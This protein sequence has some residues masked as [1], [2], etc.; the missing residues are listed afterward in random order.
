M[1]ALRFIGRARFNHVDFATFVACACLAYYSEW[2]WY[3][4][5]LIVGVSL[6]AIAEVLVTRHEIREIESLIR[7][8]EAKP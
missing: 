7:E 4:A 8:A 1:K 3:A 2:V 6:S 5:A